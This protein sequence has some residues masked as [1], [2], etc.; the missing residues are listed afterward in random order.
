VLIKAIQEQQQEIND[1]KNRLEKL[2]AAANNS[3]DVR[4][5]GATLTSMSLE[6]NVSNPFTGNTSIQ[7]NIPVKFSSAKI[8]IADYTGKALK[9]LNVTTQGKGSLQVNAS[10]LI[11]GTYTYSL[12]VDGKLMDSKKMILSK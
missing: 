7:Y 6:Q 1:Y 2:E 4:T 8:V 5:P 12:I 10:T 11:P 3:T 9:E